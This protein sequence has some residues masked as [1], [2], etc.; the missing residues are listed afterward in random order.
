MEERSEAAETALGVE[1]E[2]ENE[3]A[4]EVDDTGRRTFVGFVGAVE[5]CD[6]SARVEEE[7]VEWAWRAVEELEVDCRDVVGALL[8]LLLPP[9]PFDSSNILPLSLPYAGG[10]ASV[11]N[12]GASPHFLTFASIKTKPA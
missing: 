9:F 10:G 7:V 5:G 8:L 2:A 1:V 11:P 4:G 6:G 12:I 3:V